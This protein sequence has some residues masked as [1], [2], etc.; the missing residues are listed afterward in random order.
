MGTTQRS[1][2]LSGGGY[3]IPD[4]AMHKRGE[5]K[6]ILCYDNKTACIIFSLAKNIEEALGKDVQGL[7]PHIKG[8]FQ[9]VRHQ[10]SCG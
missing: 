1:V 7:A 10:I 8:V 9:Q 4:V 5:P 2:S 3:A 6:A